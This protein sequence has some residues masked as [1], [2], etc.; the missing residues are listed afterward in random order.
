MPAKGD[1]MKK[2]FLLVALMLVLLVC[3]FAISVSAEN[4]LK[5]Q[6]NNA[7]GELSFFDEGITVGRTNAKYGFTPYID[8]EGT[9]YARVVVGDGTTFYTFPTAYVLSEGTIYGEGQI[10]T[11]VRDMTSL[12]TAMQAATGTNPN[13]NEDNI[14]RIELPHTVIRLNGG[15]QQAFQGYDNVIEIRLQPNSH[16]KDQNKTMIFWKCFNLE[17]IHNLDTFTFRN[18]CL[19]GSFQECKKLKNLTFGYSPEVTTTSTNAFIGCIALESVNLFEAF[20]NLTEIGKFTFSGCT[21]LKSV[22]SATL[23]QEGA[24]FVQEGVTWIGQEAFYNCD[25]IKYLSLPSTV[26]YLGPSVARDCGALEFVDFNENANAINLD[27]WGHFNSCA[28][29][30]AMSMPDGIQIINNRFANSCGN[31]QAVYLPASLK[32]MNTNGNGQGPF[33]FDG[34]LYFVEEPFEVRDENGLFYGNSFVMP[35][36]PDTYYMPSNLATAGGNAS[37]GTWFRDCASLNNVIVMPAAFTQSTVA[38]MFRGIASSSQRKTVV[39]LGKITDICW[40]EMNKYIDFVFANPGNTDLSTINFTAFYNRNNENCYFYFCSTGYR[41]TMAASDATAVA[42]TKI[43]NSYHHTCDIKKSNITPATCIKNAFGTLK[44]FCGFEMGTQEIANSATGVHIYADDHNCATSD[45]CTSDPDCTMA[46]EALVHELIETLVYESYLTNGTYNACCKNAGCEVGKVDNEIKLPLFVAGADKGYSTN[47]TGI[48][49][50]GYNVNIDALKEFNRVNKDN[51][52]KFGIMLVNPNYLDGKSTFMQ[53]GLV[54]AEKG[55]LQVD[56]SNTEYSNISVMVNGFTGSAANLSLVIS[57]Y[58][59][60][61]A[62]D[63]EFIQSED[64]KCAS[65]KVTK[66]DATLYT[67]TYK[68]VSEAFSDVSNLGEYVVP[69][70]EQIA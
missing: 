64:T 38:Q 33:C 41:Y 23:K 42:A 35:S 37:S 48:A 28:N 68:S 26:T 59:Y 70:K 13:W 11:Y 45:K 10:N 43:E 18:G 55:H 32:Q 12:N 61:D 66:D 9:T 16:V 50:G 27:N 63:V 17:T 44:C 5:P 46:T 39:Y 22:Y 15:S 49:F 24:I 8:A 21:N 52:L 58:A 65:A 53:N 3:L 47:G 69:P 2:R 36:K 1:F 57:L 29:L 31:L 4:A 34:K 67:V 30:K 7:Y 56:M 19:S 60:T 51:T 62:D 20:P 54:N 14:Y 25:S 40:S 6:D